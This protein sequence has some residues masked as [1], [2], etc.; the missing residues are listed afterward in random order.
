MPEEDSSDL[1]TVQAAALADPVRW[2]LY[3]TLYIIGSS[4]FGLLSRS[5]APEARGGLKQQLEVLE[6]AALVKFLGGKGHER[7]WEAL[8]MRVE[9]SWP[10][11]LQKSDPQRYLAQG[12]MEMVN[13]QLKEDR[14]REFLAERRAGRWSPA[15]TESASNMYWPVEMTPQQVA[16]LEREI[17]TVV[18]R[19]QAAASKDGEGGEDRQVVAVT[20]SAMPFRIRGYEPG[21]REQGD[22]AREVLE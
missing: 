10:R 4:T 21:A 11:N 20:F 3:E 14:R 6:N 13:E 8:P 19:H 1:G 2:K 17:A 12:S 18:K 7:R 15:W 5:L 9:W 22:K 16:A